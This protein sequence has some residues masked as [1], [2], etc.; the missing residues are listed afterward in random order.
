MY[1]R[2]H[3]HGMH[4]R[5][6]FA[7]Y[8]MSTHPAVSRTQSTECMLHTEPSHTTQTPQTWWLCCASS[9]P[10]L[11]ATAHGP[12]AT[13]STMPCFRLSLSLLKPWLRSGIWIAR[14][15][16]LRARVLGSSCLSSAG[17]RSGQ[18]PAF[19][20][21]MLCVSGDHGYLAAIS[22]LSSCL[23]DHIITFSNSDTNNSV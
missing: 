13:P 23:Q 11:G 1:S 7:S 15:R 10:R 5:L 3:W 20:S 21:C 18:V 2:V 16:F 22:A 4:S 19:C 6:G 12:A 17:T 14:M 8:R 9:L